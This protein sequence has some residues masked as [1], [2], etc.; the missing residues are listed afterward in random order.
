MKKYLLLMLIAIGLASCSTVEQFTLTDVTDYSAFTNRG[1][2]V[3]ESNSVNFDYEPL[4]S[5]ISIT[6][7][8]LS[9]FGFKGYIDVDKAFNEIAT[10]I[11]AKGANGL[12]NLKISYLEASKA[13]IKMVVS[14]MAIRTDKPI[15]TSNNH[16]VVTQP[17]S[18]IHIDGIHCFIFKKFQS[19]F[20]VMTDSA[21]TIEQVKKAFEEF[22]I[23]GK[24]CQFFLPNTK[25]PYIG[26]TEN[27]YII[28]YA[29]NEFIPLK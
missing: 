28:N 19:G 9:S 29:T 16:S 1:I 12:I 6:Q 10:K 18:D 20:A 17:K 11:E 2:F 23:K 14:G 22:A 24:E 25:S 13:S 27:G 3:T 7:S 5:V 4:G 26:I 15:I 21:L 8:A